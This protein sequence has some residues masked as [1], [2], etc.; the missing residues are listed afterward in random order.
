MKR[1]L[2]YPDVLRA[3]A[4]VATVLF[5]TCVA[6]GYTP[7][8]G[9][10]T[11]VCPMFLMLSG[12]FFLDGSW[13]LSGKELGKRY[14][15]RLVVAYLVWGMF[16][17]LV[18]ALTGNVLQGIL[19]G[20]SCYLNFLFVLFILYTFS[21][22]LRV[23]TRAAQPR[24]LAYLVVFGVLLGGVYPF[25]QSQIGSVR[26][27]DYA[28]MGFGYLGVFAAGWYLRTAF[29]TR[30]QLRIFYLLGAVCVILAFRGLWG[31][32]SFSTD[33]AQLMLSPDALLIATAI[34]LVT[35]NTLAKKRLSA[36]IMRPIAR[37][38]QLSFGI[39]LIHPILLAVLCWVLN[40][41]GIYLPAGLFVVGA[42]AL[43]LVVSGGLTWLI[44]KIPT[45]G[46]YLV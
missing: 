40:D 19:T 3:A 46:R 30:K 1:R 32:D 35:K 25:V 21:P 36:K 41:Y 34:F 45:V 16:A 22:V 2:V 20:S 27:A 28:L 7:A 26:V 9:L 8:I 17:M 23:F 4:C 15:L 5:S 42:S 33:P 39:Y 11:W 31:F 24:E 18:N 44:R 43:L 37:L 6:A 14:V 38:A 10:L 29:L 13:Y 12:M